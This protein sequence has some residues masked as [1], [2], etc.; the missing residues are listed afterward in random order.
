MVRVFRAPRLSAGDRVVKIPKPTLHNLKKWRLKCPPTDLVF[1]N[2]DLHPTGYKKFTERQWRPSLK[3]AG[4][5]PVTFHSLRHFNDQFSTSDRPESKIY[6]SQIGHSDVALILNRYGHL[7]RDSN[8]ETQ[9]HSMFENAIK[10][11]ND[12]QINQGI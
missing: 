4:L 2:R 6:A 3:K 9:Q 1:P 12:L 7:L 11:S 8:F 5:P 10:S